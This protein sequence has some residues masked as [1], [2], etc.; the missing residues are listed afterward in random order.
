MTERFTEIISI[1]KVIDNQTGKEYDCLIDEELLK[2]LNKL[3]DENQAVKDIIN[4][5]N[6]MD[7][8]KDSALLDEYIGKIARVVGCEWE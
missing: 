5:L 4:E 7:F 8:Y 1:Q 3:N 2:L 6:D